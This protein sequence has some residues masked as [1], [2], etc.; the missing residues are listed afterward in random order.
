MRNSSGARRAPL[1]RGNMSRQ[2]LG[3]GRGLFSALGAAVA[4]AA[5][6]FTGTATAFAAQPTES[7]VVITKTSQPGTLGNAATGEIVTEGLGE[8]IE[9]VTFSAWPVTTVD[10]KPLDLNAQHGKN[11]AQ[12]LAA[13]AT[14][15]N[16]A[17]GSPA[18]ATGTTNAE[19]TITWTLDRG[20]YLV[21]ETAVPAG[22]TPAQDFLLSV[23]LTDPADST[24]WL[25]TIYVYPKNSLVK[26][27]K[28]GDTSNVHAVG[29]EITWTITADAPR[30][31]SD[32]GTSFLDV[33]YFRID[34]TLASELK[35]S[36]SK[37]AI[38]GVELESTDYVLAG[39]DTGSLKLMLDAVGLQKLNTANA[40]GDAPAQV[41]WTL[42][43]TI[44]SGGQNVSI[45]NQASLTTL[46]KPV[47]GPTDP[48][49]ELPEPEKPVVT[50]P[51]TGGTLVFGTQ[52]FT[53]KS[54]IGDTVL[55]GAEFK[56][57][58]SADAALAGGDGNLKPIEG[59]SVDGIWTSDENG[60]VTVDGLRRSDNIDGQIITDESKFTKYYLVETKAP[61]GHQLLAEPIEFLVLENEPTVTVV[62]VSTSSPGFTLPLTGGSGTAMFVVVGSLLV[63]TV[64][65]LVGKRR[66]KL[67]AEGAA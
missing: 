56:V 42:T 43:T 49:V 50:D 12:L 17:V 55:A 31:Q 41:T 32:D 40:N 36:S 10:G 46:T 22:V 60:V 20:L 59:S 18:T 24:K 45:T 23:P 35:Y 38:N 64:F 63:G 39:T 37:V 3:R 29:E 53:K 8:A 4:V 52:V 2:G 47:T 34:D 51:G 67:A 7:T 57:Y 5:L 25:D 15:N 30:V 26:M 58:A 16:V 61:K 11:E 54:N 66:K 1:G 9:G 28:V 13:S 33:T 44:E 6:A 65:F 27:T 19:G 48:D 62:N 21:K 14:P